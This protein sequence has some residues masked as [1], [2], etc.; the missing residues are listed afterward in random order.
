MLSNVRGEGA[1]A[2]PMMQRDPHGTPSRE[3]RLPPVGNFAP[4]PVAK[5]NKRKRGDRQGTVDGIA[6]P[7]GGKPFGQTGN[8][9]KVRDLTYI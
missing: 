7:S 3:H 5:D 6:G 4:T 8:V 1:Y 2:S 9:G